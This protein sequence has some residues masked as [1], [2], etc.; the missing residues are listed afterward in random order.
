MTY[1]N[2]L[3][4]AGRLLRIVAP[5]APIRTSASRRSRAALA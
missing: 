4:I 5:G 3:A 1:S 2:L